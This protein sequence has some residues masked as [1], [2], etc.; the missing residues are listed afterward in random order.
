MELKDTIEMMNSPDYKERFKAEYRQ[1]KIRYNKLHNMLV[2]ADAHTLDFTP[3]CPLELL[4]EQK[5]AMG[6]YLYCLE[7]RAEIEGIKL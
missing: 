2:K 5:A 3:S 7:V 4:R 6:K 1:T